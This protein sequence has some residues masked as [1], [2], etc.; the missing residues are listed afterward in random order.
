MAVCDFAL[1]V[2]RKWKDQQG[3][4]R[5]EVTFI[6]C[7]AW[8]RQAEIINQYCTKGRPL[9]LQGRLKLDQWD[10]KQTGQ[11]RSKLA[12][13]VENFQLLGGRQDGPGGGGGAPMNQDASQY[14][15]GQAPQQRAPARA[16]ARA[17]VA[18]APQQQPPAQQQPAPFNEEQQFKEDDIPF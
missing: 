14:D 15:D 10:D 1:A 4:D 8:G 11:K 5:E 9:F 7:T 16:P 6:D 18:R 13:V 2:N 12:V 17:P 3:Q